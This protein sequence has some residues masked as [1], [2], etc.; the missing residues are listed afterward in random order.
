M[1]P[2]QLL[3]VVTFTVYAIV[4][5]VSGGNQIDVAAAFTSLSLL[6][7]LISPVMSLITAIPNVSASVACLDRIQVF[8][9]KEKREEYR[10]LRTVDPPSSPNSSTSRKMPSGDSH[11][12]DR[13]P[14][15][16]EPW[17]KVRGCSFGWEKDGQ[18]IVKDVGVDIF[19]TQLTLI[20]GPVACGKSTLLKGLLGEVYLLS[21]SVE[22]TV[23]H[24]I[25]YCDQDAWLLNQSIRDNIIA[26]GSYDK[27]FYDRVIQACQLVEDIQQLPKGDMTVIGSRG[28]SL[29][30]GQKQR[31]VS[32]LSQLLS[33]APWLTH[34]E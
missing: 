32:S 13:D 30:G 4:Q 17:I 16:E 25:A 20:I 31:V 12:G 34:P 15:K 21:G 18:A 26:F 33:P 2:A 29:S 3:P 7:I 6:N 24:E 1:A 9:L 8:L 28:L 11:V 5:K 27:G 14:E 22:Y 23:P 10:I 19:S